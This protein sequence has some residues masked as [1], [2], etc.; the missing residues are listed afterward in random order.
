MS[1]ILRFPYVLQQIDQFGVFDD[2]GG[3]QSDIAFI[4]L[5]TDG[6]TAAVLDSAGGIMSMAVTDATD[7]DEIGIYSAVE[8]F[9][10][11]DNKPILAQCRLQYA[12]ANT[13][14]ANVAFG[15]ANAPVADTLVDNGAGMRT[16]GSV[17]A[18]FKVDGGTVWKC[19]SQ[20]N[21]ITTV[22]T[23]TTTAGGSS[24]QELRIEIL[25]YTS[26]L[27]QVVFSVDG[28]RL[29]DS[30]TGKDIVHTCLY[31]S[32]T[33]MAV[34]AQIKNGSTSPETLLVDYI[35]AWQKR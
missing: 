12:E 22:S 14:D 9:K 25:D 19:C 23:S 16:S 21:S 33:E 15:L 5:V 3:D 7:N 20:N 29:V 13:D 18:I 11:A 32:A 24:Y 35:G 30:T 10:H 31:A 2:F 26:T 4:D 17:F 1:A 6:G 27:C 28:K 34:F 8:M